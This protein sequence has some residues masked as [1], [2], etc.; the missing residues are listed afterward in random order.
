MN[1][2]T[3][4]HRFLETDPKDVGCEQALEFLHAY[5][6]LVASDA[7]AQEHYPGIAVHLKAC[8]PCSEDFD[9]LLAAI[10]DPAP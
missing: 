7:A 2:D 4:L 3:A 6:E 8:G 5:V 10:T 1:R 9:G